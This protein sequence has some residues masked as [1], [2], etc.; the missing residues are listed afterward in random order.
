M[1]KRLLIAADVDPQF[2]ARVTADGRFAVTQQMARD[3]AALSAAAGDCEVLVT[4]HYNK[5]T[6]SVIGNA[7]RLEL[8]AQGTSGTDNVD[9]SALAARGITLLSLPGINADAV[10]EL[11][12]GFMISLT[13]T[14]PLY[15]A[16]VRNGIWARDDC[17]TRHELRHYRLGI[18]GLGEVGRRVAAL[19]S[20]MRMPVAAFDPYLSDEQVT[21]R[22]AVRRHSLADLIAG[23]DILTLHVPLTEETAGMIGAKELALLPPAAFVINSCR[24]EVLDLPAAL[25]MLESC[26][27]AGLAVDVYDPEPPAMRWPDDPRLI[28]TPHIAGCTHEAKAT[29][30]V[31]LY[32]RICEF[33]GYEPQR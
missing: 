22:H 27:I 15:G 12:L 16:Q 31:R 32:E 6:A 24:G 5:V 29:I 10:A 18:V 33:Y 17:A 28:V 13:R 25:R 20:H 3:E 8:I 1:P 7:P 4:R 30:G 19:G 11:V 21:A 2:V 23:T 14:V 9:R 26:R